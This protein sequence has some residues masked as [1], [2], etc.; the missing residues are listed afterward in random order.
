MILRK[1]SIYSASYGTFF[2]L[3]KKRFKTWQFRLFNRTKI[4]RDGQLYIGILG[5]NLNNL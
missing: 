2:A 4:W 1:T 5:K 3:A